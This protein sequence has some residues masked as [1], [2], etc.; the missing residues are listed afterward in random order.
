[1]QGGTAYQTASL[2]GEWY[3]L[4]KKNQNMKLEKQQRQHVTPK[5]AQKLK[6]L[7]GSL[8]S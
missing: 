8:H 7:H 5:P 4:L 1:M 2:M 6:Y 3:M